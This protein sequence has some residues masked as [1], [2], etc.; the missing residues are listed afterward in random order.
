MRRMS[1]SSRR[2]AAI[3]TGA[4]ALAALL[5]AACGGG[6]DGDADTTAGPDAAPRSGPARPY[7]LGY[8]AIPASL[9]EAAYEAVF[10]LAA[11]EGDFIMIQRTVPW[12]EVGA[13][14]SLQ[15][16]TETTIA[17]ETALIRERGLSLLFAI[18][19]WEPSN[20]ARL[21]A[22]APGRGFADAA[23]TDAYV[24]YA[25]LVVQRYHPRWLALAV[26]LDAAARLRPTD[27]DAFEAAYLRAY[28]RVKEL[29]PE[30]Q[31]FVTFQLEDLQGL[32]PWGPAHSPQ[33]SLILR[34]APALDVLAV[35]SFPSF[36]FPFAADLPDTYYTR[37]AAF[38][39]PL[40]LVPAGYASE[41][42]RGGV[43]F[44]TL[45]GQR[46]FLDWILAEAEAGR[47]E[48][49]AWLAPQDPAFA[50]VPPFDLVGRMG[51]RT[52]SGEAKPALGVWQDQAARPWAPPAAAE[53][54]NGTA[55]LPDTAEAVLPPL[56]AGQ[57]TAV[58]P[59]A[60]VGGE[61]ADSDDRGDSGG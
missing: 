15:P 52:L 5:A 19:P 4:L 41:P 26:D 7:A 12:L 35:S 51:L 36:L 17:R 10:D 43:T 54:E 44:G 53:R 32:L 22:A 47:W 56:P 55:A 59:S 39:K 38:R 23:V 34:F 42:G 6:P 13:D 49:V 18:D 29:A 30:T 2:D 46:T 21:T 24:A 58:D 3:L 9:S 60:V 61:N 33:W 40:A 45:S 14:A 28:A 1:C 31:V 20:R 37:L 27:L 11:R 57:D 48:L 16:Q 25:E 8:Q 50:T